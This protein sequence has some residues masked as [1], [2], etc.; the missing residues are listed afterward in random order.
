ME[1]VA[2]LPFSVWQ[3]DFADTHDVLAAYAHVLPS[4]PPHA[5]KWMNNLM[6]MVFERGEYNEEGKLEV[7]EELIEEAER[8]WLEKVVGKPNPDHRVRFHMFRN[9]SHIF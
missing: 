9:Y 2:A 3:A 8:K 1:E 6:K 4:V 7:P 5:V